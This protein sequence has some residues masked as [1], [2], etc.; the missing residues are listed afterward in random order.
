[1]SIYLFIRIFLGLLKPLYNKI[2]CTVQNSANG[3][4]IIDSVVYLG[5]SPNLDSLKV[6]VVQMAIVQTSW[7]VQLGVVQ[8]ACSPNGGSPNVIGS[9]N[10][11]SPNILVVQS[12]I[13]QT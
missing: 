6:F 5:C 2:H 11:D 10:G 9:P 12:E 4:S 8:M 1:M 13:V 7:V 3:C